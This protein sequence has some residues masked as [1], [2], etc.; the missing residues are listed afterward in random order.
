[1]AFSKV[2]KRLYRVAFQAIWGWVGRPAPL[3]INSI[4]AYD[5][6]LAEFIARSWEHGATRGEA[7]NALSSSVAAYPELRG[8]GKLPESWFLLSCWTRLEVPCRAPPLPSVVALGLVDW[9]MGLGH[10]DFAFLI[11]VGF[12]SFLRTREL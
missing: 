12:D 8:R 6:L 4:R 3:S 1:M 11:A 5:A 9:A 10:Y 2:T 7:G